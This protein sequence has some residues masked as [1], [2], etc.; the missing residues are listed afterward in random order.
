[1]AFMGMRGTGDW[2]TD[3]NPKNWRQGILYLYPTGSAPLTGLLSKMS[4]EQ[5]D[6]AEFN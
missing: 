5:I 2:A 6:N 1:M 3:E 4:E